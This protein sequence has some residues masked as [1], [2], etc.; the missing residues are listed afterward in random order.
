M[1]GGGGF[2]EMAPSN[3]L[4]YLFAGSR[5][6]FSRGN[7][8]AKPAI[9]ETISGQLLMASLATQVRNRRG[10]REKV[11]SALAQRLVQ[12]AMLSITS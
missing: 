1:E 10:W 12:I 9:F 7:A 8:K 6:A 5:R 3:L 2:A 4:G 11:T